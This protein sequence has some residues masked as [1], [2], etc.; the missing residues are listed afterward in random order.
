M[1]QS[2]ASRAPRQQWQVGLR[3]GAFGRAVRASSG[4]TAQ[5][6]KLGVCDMRPM[7]HGVA[8]LCPV[9][10]R[11]RGL[12]RLGARL[13]RESSVQDRECWCYLPLSVTRSKPMFGDLSG[14]G[15]RFVAPGSDR[16]WKVLSP[17][18]RKDQYDC[19]PRSA[20]E[21]SCSD[22]PRAVVGPA[23]SGLGGQIAVLLALLGKASTLRAWSS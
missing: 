10:H 8:R 9:S 19:Q 16:T 20:L 13:D 11:A 21:R 3:E 17:Q 22:S 1:C 2:P 6:E 15:R 4:P 23:P 5:R 12:G 7:H 18:K 14:A